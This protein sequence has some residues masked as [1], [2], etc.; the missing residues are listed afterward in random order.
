MA[1]RVSKSQ[2]EVSLAEFAALLSEC[3]VSECTAPQSAAQPVCNDMC[4]LTNTIMV[5][6][7]QASDGYTYERSAIETW[8]QQQQRQGL[9]ATSPMTRLPMASSEL[10]PHLQSNSA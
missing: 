6:P 5:D 7:V 9:L 10:V 1:F 8:L 2:Y 3:A 4:P